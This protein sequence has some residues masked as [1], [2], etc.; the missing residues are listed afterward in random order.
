MIRHH[1]AIMPSPP[2]HARSRGA[3]HAAWRTAAAG[4]DHRCLCSPERLHITAAQMFVRAASLALSCVLMLLPASSAYHGTMDFNCTNVPLG[5]KFAS[6]VGALICGN[7][8]HKTAPPLKAAP[9]ITFGASKQASGCPK[10]GA[11]FGRSWQRIC[12]ANKALGGA[13][14][15]VHCPC[16]VY[17]GARCAR[18]MLRG[19]RPLRPAA[20]PPLNHSE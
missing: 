5:V 12:A 18:L 1:P 2:R 15:C 19:L 6:P 11:Y 14:V 4:R 17:G 13:G 16:L 20:A 10:W 7:K 9:A 8:M 3:C